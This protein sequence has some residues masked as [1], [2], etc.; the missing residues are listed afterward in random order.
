MTQDKPSENDLRLIL[1]EGLTLYQIVIDSLPG[2]PPLELHSIID[3][4]Q[5]VIS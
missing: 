2:E 3:Y 1:Y 5:G 4:P